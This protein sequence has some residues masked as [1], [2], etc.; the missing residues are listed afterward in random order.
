MIARWDE[1]AYGPQT[2]MLLPPQHV[3][4]NRLW[5]RLRA[6]L[7]T[8]GPIYTKSDIAARLDDGSARL[9]EAGNSVA[10]TLE[11]RCSTGFRILHG[12]SAEGTADEV[13]TLVSTIEAW[14]RAA[15]IDRLQVLGRR[16]LKTILRDF[17][18]REVMF[19]KDI[20]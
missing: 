19:V 15:G 1:R 3:A 4:L 10:M 16:G 6:A 2:V 17:E 20:G 9:W 14:A 5:P 13:R 11:Q 18:P 8:H 12:W 7:A